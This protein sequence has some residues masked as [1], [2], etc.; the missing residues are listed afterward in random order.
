MRSFVGCFAGKIRTAERREAVFAPRTPGA[1]ARI[2]DGAEA[3]RI[4]L[5]PLK[6]ADQPGQIAEVFNQCA[7][8]L[9]P[10]LRANLI[11]FW[12]TSLC[13]LMFDSD[14]FVNGFP[15]SMSLIFMVEILGEL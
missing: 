3:I 9:G 10:A 11:L 8:L 14:S 13:P 15:Y 5:E 6:A 7:T 4:S 12:S 2:L 1:L